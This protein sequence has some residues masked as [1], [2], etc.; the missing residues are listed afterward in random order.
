MLQSGSRRLG[1]AGVT[2]G[3]V[4]NEVERTTFAILANHLAAV[5]DAATLEDSDDLARLR[6]MLETRTRELERTI[7]R[8][9]TVDAA[10][11]L[12]L[13]NVV[14]AQD[15]A[16][17]RF[18]SELHDDA[19]QKLTAAEL[20]LQRLRLNDEHDRAIFAEASELIVR[21]E[22]SLRRLLFEVR[23][24]ALENFGGLEA[25]VRERMMMLKSLT[26]A[27]VTT[28]IAVPEDIAYELKSM[29]FRQISEAVTNIE[30]HAR[31]T[32]VDL[33][34]VLREGTIQ[35]CIVDNGVGFVIAERNNLPGH[36]GLLSIRERSILAGGW[37]KIE[38][39]PGAGTRIEFG[40]PTT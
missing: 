23:P 30:K 20:H 13:K 7:A 15:K 4:Y 9:E 22:E 12:L 38:S 40:L 1:V 36:L 24:P 32:K 28:E 2:R 18:A 39:E 11:Q 25:T 16:A 10:R 35:G 19:M 29:V 8:L 6:K 14:T 17:K 5:I 3:P 26:N 37:Y 27:E 21:T 33:S 34:L 31:A